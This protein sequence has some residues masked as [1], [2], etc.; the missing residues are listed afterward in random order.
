MNSRWTPFLFCA[1]SNGNPVPDSSYAGPQ[2]CRRIARK[3]RR[4]WHTE[5]ERQSRMKRSAEEALRKRIATGKSV[6]SKASIR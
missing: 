6:P 5:S 1:P 3:S 4:R 2:T